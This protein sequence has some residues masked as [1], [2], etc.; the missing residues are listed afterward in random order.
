M[1]LNSFPRI[2]FLILFLS[3]IL[4]VNCNETSK[5]LPIAKK[6]ILDLRKNIIGIHDKIPLNG[7]W[8]FSWQKF[9]QPNEERSFNNSE[10]IVNLPSSWKTYSNQEGLLFPR[11]GFGTYRLKILLP[12]NAS[13]R[14]IK[15]SS[16]QK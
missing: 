11:E 7:E 10:Q 1:I 16:S 15:Y 9:N 13:K 5:E 3:I 12:A 6:G 2:S 8:E 4:T 14:T